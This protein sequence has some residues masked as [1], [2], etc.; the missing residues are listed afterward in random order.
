MSSQSLHVKH[1]FIFS[2]KSKLK[3]GR[4]SFNTFFGSMNIY[5][6]LIS[7]LNILTFSIL[8]IHHS[9]YFV[10]PMGL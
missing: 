9:R 7:M 10:P 1:A 4:I 5:E 3:Y 2:M 8:S 6:L